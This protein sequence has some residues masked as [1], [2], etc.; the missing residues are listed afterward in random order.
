MSVDNVKIWCRMVNISLAVL[1]V[2]AKLP[3]LNHCQYFRIDSIYV[4]FCIYM[5]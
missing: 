4:L 3:N 5:L 1:P 2:T